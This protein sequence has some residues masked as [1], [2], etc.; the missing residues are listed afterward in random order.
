MDY[1]NREYYLATF[2]GYKHDEII[3]NLKKVIP[4][5]KISGPYNHFK[6]NETTSKYDGEYTKTFGKSG[7]W[8][9]MF[10]CKKD[11]SRLF[12]SKLESA[13]EGKNGYF[14]KLDQEICGQ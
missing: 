12:E 5:L 7:Y 3:V 14:L 4:S 9:M 10:S 6:E 11:Y 1:R 8:Q 13:C 2:D